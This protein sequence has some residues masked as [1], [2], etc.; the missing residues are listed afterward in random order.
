[1]AHRGAHVVVVPEEL[2]QRLGFRWRLHDDEGL[3]HRCLW[4]EDRAGF[5]K[6][7]VP[8]LPPFTIRSIDRRRR[9]RPVDER[10]AH[11][12][13]VPH[14]S[15]VLP[16]SDGPRLGPFA[17]RRYGAGRCR[18]RR[19]RSDGPTISTTSWEAIGSPGTPGRV[20][21]LDRGWSTVIR[22]MAE[23]RG[24]TEPLRRAQHR[25][26]RGGRRLGRAVRR[27]RARRARP[28]TSERVHPT[29]LVRRHARGVAHARREHRRGV[30]RARAR[31]A[32][33]PA[34]PRARARAGLRLRRRSG[35]RADE[36]R[37]RRRSGAR[38]APRSSTWRSACRCCWRAASPATVSRR[39]ARYAVGQPDADVPRGERRRQVDAR[40]RARSATNAKPPPPSARAISAGVTRRWPPNW[41]RCPVRA[42]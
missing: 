25:R 2:R 6:R 16:M 29:R 17:H 36:D 12:S 18:H 24:T 41:C 31:L 33:E 22:S 34:P 38:R 14:R 4:L 15:L 27:R 1:M 8:E 13:A 32:A 10:T 26:R 30:P 39:S 42:G 3:G 37:P 21:R 9:L 23:A 20:S 40:E 28:R 5:V 35:G 11:P 19:R 7:S